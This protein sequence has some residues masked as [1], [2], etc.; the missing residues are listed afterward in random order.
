MPS[1]FT[2]KSGERSKA[3]LKRV[4][5]LRD[6]KAA[7]SWKAIAQ[8]LEVSPRTVRRMYDEA[9]GEGAHFESRLEG[10]GGRT[11]QAQPAE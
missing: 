2:T 8:E 10:K 6:G 4:V 11:R 5:Q 3:T 9:K 1:K 7:K